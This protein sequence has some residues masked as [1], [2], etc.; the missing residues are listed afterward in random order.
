MFPRFNPL[1]WLRFLLE[2][3]NSLKLFSSIIYLLFFGLFLLFYFLP[4]KQFLPHFFDVELFLAAS[5]SVF[6]FK[7]VSVAV[8]EKTDVF[9]AWR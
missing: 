3:N 9:S 5:S 7:V 8:A 1:L 4:N 2:G 6:E